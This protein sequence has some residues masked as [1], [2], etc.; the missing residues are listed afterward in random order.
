M[1]FLQF[2]I[3]SYKDNEYDTP[4]QGNEAE[5]NLWQAIR[6]VVNSKK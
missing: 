1:H 2:E 6:K 3:F 4:I 5:K